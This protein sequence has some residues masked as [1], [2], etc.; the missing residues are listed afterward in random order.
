MPSQLLNGFLWNLDLE[1]DSYESSKAEAIHNIECGN[2]YS[3]AKII[4]A[5][6]KMVSN[7]TYSQWVADN[8]KALKMQI[9]QL[10]NLQ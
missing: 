6:W 4:A 9:E 1:Y 5:A 3:N 10:E 7:E 2:D 8:I